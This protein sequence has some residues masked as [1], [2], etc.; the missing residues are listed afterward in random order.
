M[1][2][3]KAIVV[4]QEVSPYT[5]PLIKNGSQNAA[6][7]KTFIFICAKIVKKILIAIC[8]TL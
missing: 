3:L 6:T 4:P 8:I 2:S 5:A 1:V 7:H